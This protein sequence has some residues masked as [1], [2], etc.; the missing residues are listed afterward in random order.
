MERCKRNSGEKNV[1]I[2]MKNFAVEE[3]VKQG[4]DKGGRAST[5][6]KI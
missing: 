2:K 3:R 5:I 6:R 4:K 1:K